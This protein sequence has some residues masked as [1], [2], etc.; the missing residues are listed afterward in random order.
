MKK[1]YR[2]LLVV[3][4]SVVAISA[5]AFGSTKWSEKVEYSGA[6]AAFALESEGINIRTVDT[7][8]FP[9]NNNGETETAETATDDPNET[10]SNQSS[11]EVAS[12]KPLTSSDTTTSSTGNNTSSPTT[13]QPPTTNVS[14][15]DIKQEYMARFLALE[16]EISSQLEATLDSLIADVK[17]KQANNENVSMRDIQ[18]KLVTDVQKLESSS[19]QQFNRIYQEL[20]TDLVANGYSKNEASPSRAQYSAEKRLREQKAIQK[21][22][23][24]AK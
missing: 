17:T 9:T 5:V 4:T 10:T 23:E 18:N 3:T 16:M 19:D 12:S 11:T 14:L 20:E 8:K 6:E 13:E 2:N 21:L 1:V 24:L 7:S 15:S 22:A